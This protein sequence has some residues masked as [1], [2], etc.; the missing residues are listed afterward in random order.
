VDEPH[1]IKL[2]LPPELDLSARDEAG[3]PA[4][5]PLCLTLKF[6]AL[7]LSRFE[8]VFKELK[9]I[10]VDDERG[11][12]FTCGVWPDEH[13][14]PR[15]RSAIPPEELKKRI[16]T[17]YRTVDLLEHVKLPPRKATYKVYAVLE[18]YKSNVATIRVEAR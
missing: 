10:L 15:Q 18:Q 14:A 9:V 1:G 5:L 17:E 12:T 3:E 16:A 7:Y 8:Y 6:D 13:L 11:E 4:K 2:A